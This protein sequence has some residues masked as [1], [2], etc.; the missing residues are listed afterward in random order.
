MAHSLPLLPRALVRAVAA[1]SC[2]LADGVAYVWE[3]QLWRA[4][5]E[6]VQGKA[7]DLRS[8]W[9]GRSSAE[10]RGRA[11][12]R[13]SAPGCAMRVRHLLFCSAGAPMPHARTC[14]LLR[15]RRRA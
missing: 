6:V 8:A 11:D 7:G 15:H 4:V 1:H 3:E 9:K 14:N 10:V 5:R 13:G 2:V 12:K